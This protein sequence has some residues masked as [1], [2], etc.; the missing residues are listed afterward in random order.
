MRR[1]FPSVMRRRG[2]NSAK[3]STYLRER[4]RSTSTGPAT[5]IAS[6]PNKRNID[7]DPLSHQVLRD[8]AFDCSDKYNFPAFG[9]VN[10]KDGDT[11]AKEVQDD[12]YCAMAEKRGVDE[13]TRPEKRSSG[14]APAP[15]TRMP[16]ESI[17]YST[18]HHVLTMN[19]CFE[20]AHKKLA[21]ARQWA[22]E[23]DRDTAKE[24]EILQR[25]KEINAQ[26]DDLAGR[27]GA[28]SSLALYQ[29]ERIRVKYHPV[30]FCAAC[31]SSVT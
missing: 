20:A 9:N 13:D 17:G 12:K 25:E 15:T 19:Y 2:S 31:R 29:M 23:S 18:K 4:P 11:P 14:S 3:I 7:E 26:L 10:V 30:G 6:R 24:S 27:V 28:F 5:R 22:S 16:R 1:R 21:A 8:Y